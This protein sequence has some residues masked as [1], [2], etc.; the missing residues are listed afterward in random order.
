MKVLVN[1]VVFRLKETA[2]ASRAEMFVTVQGKINFS[3]AGDLDPP[4]ACHFA[5]SV[6]YFKIRSTGVVDHVLGIHYDYDNH[7]P[8]HP[9]FHAQLTS[10]AAHLATVNAH[11][12][13]G[14]VLGDD[15]MKGVA[16]KVRLP[17]AH[18]DPLSV[19]V[20]L[21]ADHLVNQNSG[22][23]VESAFERTRSALMFFNSDSSKSR[24]LDDV[25][26]HR[27]F[28]GPRWY[29]AFAPAPQ[30]ASGAPAPPATPLGK[31]A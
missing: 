10:C 22:P 27:C 18:M 3:I 31:A 13:P 4:L 14:L 21:L 5:T 29:P 30:P 9:V 6:G 7:R 20:Q 17:T 24:R 19:F 28:R 8:V 15:L 26:A 2:R 23:A 25:S 1:P 11:Y 12:R 16:D